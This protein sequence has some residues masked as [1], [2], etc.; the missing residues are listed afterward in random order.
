[1]DFVDNQL[2]QGTGTM[3]GRAVISN[4]DFLLTPGLFARLRLP[5]GGKY[6]ALLIPDAA[7]LSDQAEKFVWVLDEQNRSRWSSN[8]SSKVCMISVIRSVVQIRPLGQTCPMCNT[9]VER[10]WE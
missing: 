6:Q 7:V 5:G 10:N 8:G 4:P 1:M 3:V 2:D 9:R